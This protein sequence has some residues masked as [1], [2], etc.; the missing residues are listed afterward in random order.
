[1]SSE[2]TQVRLDIPHLATGDRSVTT[3]GGP[4]ATR[5]VVGDAAGLNDV[6]YIANAFGT[7]SVQYFSR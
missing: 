3:R 4:Y 1:M 7:Q 5:T 6:N 2:E